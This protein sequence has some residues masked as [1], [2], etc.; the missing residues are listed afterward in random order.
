ME[1]YAYFEKQHD[2][3]TKIDANNKGIMGILLNPQ[4]RYA[5]KD[6]EMKKM[7]GEFAKICCK[8]CKK[9]QT[10]MLLRQKSRR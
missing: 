6:K 5:E 1:E 4:K 10:K 7:R 2:R 9:I 3:G 8:I